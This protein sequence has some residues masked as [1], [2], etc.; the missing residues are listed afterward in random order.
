MLACGTGRRIRAVQLPGVIGAVGNER[1]DLRSHGPTGDVPPR[2]QFAEGVADVG[3]RLTLRW[4]VRECARLDSMALQH[5]DQLPLGEQLHPIRGRLV[6]TNATTRKE[7][8]ERNDDHGSSL[9]RQPTLLQS[10]GGVLALGRLTAAPLPGCREQE[11]PEGDR[12]RG[13]EYG[14]S[15][16]PVIEAE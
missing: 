7:A 11:A 13:T 5:G 9:R 15:G 8:A 16:E 12:D 14:N 4:P 6:A 10:R 2:E 1:F 3:I